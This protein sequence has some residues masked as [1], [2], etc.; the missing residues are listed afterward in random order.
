MEI[1]PLH[2]ADEWSPLQTAVVYPRAGTMLQ[3]R[4]GYIQLSLAELLKAEG[5]ELL[6]PTANPN[7]ERQPL[8]ARDPLFV[9]DNQAFI[10]KIGMP[11]R[12]HEDERMSALLASQ[13][14]PF[15]RTHA[16]GGDVMLLPEKRMILGIHAWKE[17][18]S[19]STYCEEPHETDRPVIE[20][21]KAVRATVHTVCH[22]DVHADCAIAPLPDGSF[23]WHRH[24][25][26][27]A[28]TQDLENA[29]GR[30]A[31]TDIPKLPLKDEN[32]RIAFETRT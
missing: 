17:D 15:T 10:A 27:F 29:Y 21:M 28:A 22:H 30:S 25:L 9:V 6:S 31:F 14:L 2:V 26:G 16:H 3:C 32:S 8:Y 5:V 20:Q 7:E 23:L 19:E 18:P 12:R 4:R 13:N 1:P 24:R 11:R